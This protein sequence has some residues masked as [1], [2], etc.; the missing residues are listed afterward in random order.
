MKVAHVVLNLDYGGLEKCVIH[1]VN[2]IK[3]AGIETEIICL[4]DKGSLAVEAER[5]GVKVTALNKPEGFKLGYVF[6][7][8]DLIKKS[9]ADI[10]HSHNFGPLIYASLA[11]KLAGKPCMHTR[12]GRKEEWVFSF[13]WNINDAIVSVS[14]DTKNHLLSNNRIDQ[15]RMR[16]I[17]NGIDTDQYSGRMTDEQKTALREELGISQNSF[18]ITNVGRLSKEKDQ[19]TLIKA[20]SYLRKKEMDADLLLVGDGPVKDELVSLAKE[21]K[22]EDRVRFVGF[23]D[24]IAELLAVSQIFVLSSF[25]EGV[26]LSLLEAMASGVPVVAT[27][28]GGNPEV[29]KDGESGILVPC[30]F[31]ERIEAAIMRMYVNADQRSTMAN[32]ARDTA[33]KFFSLKTMVDQYIAT[34]EELKR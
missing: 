27:K 24:D 4:K 31:P 3:E 8:A 17:Y 11:A 28:V 7:L 12:H 6:K 26:P 29:V 5:E 34:Y 13:I 15:Q 10:V 20:F 9:N 14:N 19:F 2:N 16:V 1:L 21:L 23:R 22:V 33:R 32:N 25:R 30:G 18:V